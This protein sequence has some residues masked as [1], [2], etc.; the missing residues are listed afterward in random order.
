MLAKRKAEILASAEA[1]I[2]TS[3]ER[4]EFAKQKLRTEAVDLATKKDLA[5]LKA[6]LLLSADEAEKTNTRPRYI[7]NNVD[8]LD[9]EY[10][11]YHFSL[12]SSVNAEARSNTGQSLLS[13]AT[14]NNDAAMV[15]FLLTHWKTC[16]TDRYCTLY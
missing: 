14:Q 1:R 13:I 5:G 10:N 2:R 8:F 7:N 4:E 6:M 16:D 9:L 3:A 12:F 11:C 15:E